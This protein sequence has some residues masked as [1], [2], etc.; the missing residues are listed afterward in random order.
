VA[1]RWVQIAAVGV[2]N[3]EV[4]FR[5]SSGAVIGLFQ[6]PVPPSSHRAL[7]TEDDFTRQPVLVQRI[8]PNATDM[9]LIPVNQWTG[10]DSI[11]R[12][13]WLAVCQATRRRLK[14]TSLSLPQGQTVLSAYGVDDMASHGGG[15]RH[16]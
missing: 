16:R 6:F 8:E 14:L 12:C 1:V 4:R 7:G 9:I 13:D 5:E 10:D 2:T 15:V 3:R 11:D